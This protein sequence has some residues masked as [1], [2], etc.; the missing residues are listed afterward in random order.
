MQLTSVNIGRAQPLANAKAS[1]VTGIY[2]RPSV[3][4]VMIGPTGLERDVICD[5]ENHGG[6]D[7]AVYLYG[8]PDYLWWSVELGRELA[9]GTFGENLTVA[10]LKS[11]E[12][13]VGD[14]LHVGSEVVL[15]VTAPRLPCVTL[16]R[17]MDDPS[18]VKRF[19]AAERP[20]AYCRVIQ[21]GLVCAGD[22]V[23]HAPYAGD[24]LSMLELFRQGYL[25]HQ[26]EAMLRRRLALPIAI[27]DRID[28]QRALANLLK[29]EEI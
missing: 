18:F 20:G 25:K 1:G 3:D 23:A 9:P 26:D 7:Q 10:E 13:C 22:H 24:R 29:S 16:A 28:T 8:V 17:R 19:R 21:P 2:K 4:A 14:R 27:R 11:A 6:P 5:V 15:E 12:L